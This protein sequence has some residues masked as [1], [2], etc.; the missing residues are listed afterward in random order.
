MLRVYSAYNSPTS[1]LQPTKIVN[2]FVAAAALDPHNLLVLLNL[3][4]FYELLAESAI[5]S[6]VDSSFAIA[7]EQVQAQIAKVRAIRENL[8]KTSSP[9]R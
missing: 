5:Q 6:R 7:P 8:A 2:D 9:L 3:Q 1:R 4:S